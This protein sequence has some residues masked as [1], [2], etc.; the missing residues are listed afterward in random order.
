MSRGPKSKKYLILCLGHVWN[1]FS[2]LLICAVLEY[3]LG[4]LGSTVSF[5]ML[6][7]ASSS[8]SG[9]VIRVPEIG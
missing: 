8:V 6:Q 7:R 2:C 4:E 1:S 3:Q 9:L 5:S